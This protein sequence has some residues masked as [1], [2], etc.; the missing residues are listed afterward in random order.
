M[1][2]KIFQ[3]HL[4]CHEINKNNILFSKNNKII[5]KDYNFKIAYSFR[6]GRNISFLSKSYFISKI[7]RNEIFNLFMLRDKFVFSYKS[8]IFHKSMNENYFFKGFRGSRP[9]RILND[10]H[11]NKLL[12]GEYFGNRD[13]NEVNIFCKNLDSKWFKAYTFKSK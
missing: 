5:V 2:F 1:K 11:N 13:R 12:F 8:K 6:I 4:K 10:F 7:L 9:L 3:R